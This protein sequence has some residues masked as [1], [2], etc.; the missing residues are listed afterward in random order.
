M[1]GEFRESVLEV[2]RGIPEGQTMTYGDVAVR[3]GRPGAS[4]AV[5]SIMRA[6]RNPEVP[7]HRVVSASGLGGYNRGVKEKRRRL[8]SE[9]ALLH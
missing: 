7:C 9:G 3:A 8:L 4:R 1:T 2:V 6:N 5:G